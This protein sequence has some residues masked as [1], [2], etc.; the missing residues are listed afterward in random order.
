MADLQATSDD[1]Y[2][3][4]YKQIADFVQNAVDETRGIS[5]VELSITL[6][7]CL[8]DLKKLVSSST[9]NEASREKV[10]KGECF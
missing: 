4:R 5:A 3:S 10:K 9:K 2:S 8:D 6:E 1:P 7:Q